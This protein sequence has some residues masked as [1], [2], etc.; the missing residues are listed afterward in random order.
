[1]LKYL[2][3]II[4]LIPTITYANEVRFF[5][6]K[7]LFESPLANPRASNSGVTFNTSKYK[8]IR[9][10]YLE[11]SVGREVP[12]V[13]WDIDLWAVQFG[14]EATTWVTLGYP[15]DG[16]SFPLLTQD[17]HFAFPLAVRYGNV[18]AVIKFNH[19]SAH[20]GDGF[21]DLAEEA[22]SGQDLGK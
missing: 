16:L 6:D 18:S 4:T 17:F 21:D 7:P 5:Q 10:L 14:L 12:I 22:L 9:L 19:I 20:K 13:T 2:F 8:G 1:M 15:R 3:F 11:G